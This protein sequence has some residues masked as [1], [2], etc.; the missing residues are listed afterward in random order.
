MEPIF[1]PIC[2]GQLYLNRLILYFMYLTSSSSSF[3]LIFYVHGDLR[4]R[5][6][7]HRGLPHDHQQEFSKE[8]RFKEDVNVIDKLSSTN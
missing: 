6:R 5:R 2:G 7:R 1:R 8:T 3:F 4:K